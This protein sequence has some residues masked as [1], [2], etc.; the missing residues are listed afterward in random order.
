MDEQIAVELRN[1]TKRFGEVVAVDDVSLRIQ[2]GEFF[3]LLGP[4]GCGKTTTLRII[5][6]FETP[7]EGEM[8]IQGELMGLT[9]PFQRNTNMV[10]QEY[11]LFPHMSVAKNVAFGLEM[12]KVPK[13][14]IARRVEEALELVRL[15]GFGERRPD[16]LSGGQQQRV[17]L[18][19]ALINRPGV[20]LLDEP[21]GSLDLKLRKEMQLELKG[22]QHRLGITF[23]YVTHDQEEALTM[24]DRIA[25][26]DQ[27]KALQVGTPTEI[28]ERP[29]SRFVADFIG[30]T[31]FLEG[32]VLTR[33]GRHVTVEVAGM[34][35]LIAQSAEELAPGEA[36]TVA[37]RPEKIIIQKED[38]EIESNCCQG[39]IENVVYIGTD[40]NY[41]VRLDSGATVRV[42]EQNVLPSLGRGLDEGATAFLLWQPESSS[43]LPD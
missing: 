8:Y 11:A 26:M 37:L 12:K 40:T 7:T 27:G 2:D 39:T 17:A 28:Y 36:V 18:A 43:L 5:A 21:L 32:V 33:D 24:S 38:P 35:A 3:S 30:E 29:A 19:R 41:V 4:S 16:Q 6:G 1:V 22:L 31:N 9:P 34:P 10:F 42:R 14:E 20:L 25:V 13:K 23:V 15:P